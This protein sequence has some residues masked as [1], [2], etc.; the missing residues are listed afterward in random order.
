M[1]VAA[2][3]PVNRRT[4]TLSESSFALIEQMRQDKP[5]SVFVEKL[6][7]AEAERRA[8][9]QFYAQAVAAYTSEI[10]DQT[11]ALNADYPIDEA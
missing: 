6:L 2:K 8:E 7:Q 3:S 9:R 1:K 5:K 4:L 11:H 10:T